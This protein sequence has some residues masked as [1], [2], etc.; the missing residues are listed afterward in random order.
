M[1]SRS[2]TN[3]IKETL[4]NSGPVVSGE[5]VSLSKRR[6]LFSLYQR[7]NKLHASVK[8]TYL[9]FSHA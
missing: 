5:Q 8:K 4:L 9:Q 2:P 7:Q 3:K 1:L 6:T